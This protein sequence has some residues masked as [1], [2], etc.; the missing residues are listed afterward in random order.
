VLEAIHRYKYNRAFW[1]E[2]FLAGLLTERAGPALAREH[3]DG[4]VPVPL[5][6]TKQREREFNQAERL[7]ARLS[8]ASGIPLCG[9]VLRRV[10]ATQTQTELSREERMANVRGAFAVRRGTSLHG[11]RLVVVD[12][13]FTTG[14]TT[15]ACARPLLDA[16]AAAVSVWTL[17][18]GI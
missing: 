16:G 14:A 13:V 2:P 11:Q 15:S 17:A 1:L 12:D 5:H 6:P 8:R 18:R 9:R 10:V 3:W 4:L 7:A